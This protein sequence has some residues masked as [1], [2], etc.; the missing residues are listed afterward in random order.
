MRL[1]HAAVLID[2]GRLLGD[3]TGGKIGRIFLFD[4]DDNVSQI[5]LIGDDVFRVDRVGM[6]LGAVRNSGHVNLLGLGSFAVELCGS[7]QISAGDAAKAQ[8]RGGGR[9]EQ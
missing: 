1:V 9:N 7:R 8:R 6:K 4:R 2:R 3:F 5:T